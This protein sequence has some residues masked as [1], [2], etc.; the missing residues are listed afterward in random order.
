MTTIP[1]TM[2]TAQLAAILA[3]SLLA[4]PLAAQQRP[5]AARPPVEQKPALRRDNANARDWTL[6][7][8]VRLHSTQIRGTD[9]RNLPATPQFILS[10]VEFLYPILD[11]SAMHEVYPSRMTS[12]FRIDTIPVDKEPE[13]RGGYQSL[14]SIGVWKAGA[15]KTHHL[16]FIAEIPMTC[17]ETRIDETIARQ[18]RWPAAPWS[19]EMALCLEPQLFVE[20]KDEAVAAL[21]KK[22]AKGDPRAARPYDLAKTIAAGVIEH[23]R[24]T[25]PPTAARSRGVEVGHASAVLLEGFVVHG[26]AAVAREKKGSEFDLACLLTAAYRSAGLPARLVIG[27]DVKRS[28]ERQGTVLRSWTEFFLAREPAP[29]ATGAAAAITSNDGEWIPVDIFRQWEFSSRAPPPSQRWEYFGHNEEFD[30]VVPIAFHWL[31]PEDCTNSGPPG[32]WGW[33]PTPVNPSCDAEVKLWAYET[34]RKGGVDPRP[35]KK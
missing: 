1:S 22:W 27:L 2:R 20:S 7:A 28:E 13:I 31:P 35:R 12:E 10:G 5:T 34:P 4:S 30:F 19:A 25:D 26:A 18:Y 21:V 8:E 15:M 23:M 6:H 11:S 29:T 24:V 17:W 14:S 9:P 16:T 3:A 33:R 32:I